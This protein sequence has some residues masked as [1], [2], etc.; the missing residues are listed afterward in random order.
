MKNMT[1]KKKIILWFSLA[2][3]IIVAIIQA[4]T[5]AIVNF[6][7]STDLK[8]HLENQVTLNAGE[9]EYYNS[10]EGQEKE[11]GDQYLSY[12]NGI[13]EIDVVKLEPNI[14]VNSGELSLSTDK[15]VLTT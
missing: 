14:A 7:F 10:I 3:F 2:L 15:T 12:K 4:L 13:L 1:I 5:F 8:G 6:V 9:I 11:V